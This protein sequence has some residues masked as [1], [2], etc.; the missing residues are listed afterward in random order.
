[1][2]TSHAHAHW[3]GM[4]GEMGLFV[5]AGVSL[6]ALAVADCRQRK[7]RTS[8]FLALW[9]FGVFCFA[10]Y[11]NYVINVRTMIPLVPAAAILVARALEKNG[12]YRRR[13]AA[14]LLLPLAL[15]GAV[16]LWIAC[17]DTA[18]GE[19]QR[20]AARCLRP[21]VERARVWFEGRWGLE[22]YMELEGARAFDR[23]NSEVRAG[24]LLV[25]PSLQDSV[26]PNRNYR[27]ERRLHFA[28]PAR[29]ATQD[30]DLGAGFYS[31][32]HGPLPF[33][34]GPVAYEFSVL[35]LEF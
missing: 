32:R 30:W 11:T 33:A 2:A 31:S 14:H 7:D 12:G 25:V 34:F 27:L 15:T 9:V 22:Y 16:A 20:A 5:A 10:V 3:I 28:V 21:E 35:K 1:V 4:C 6:L 19:A 23:S 24:D 26:I 17:G 8:W 29:V 13:R 18:F